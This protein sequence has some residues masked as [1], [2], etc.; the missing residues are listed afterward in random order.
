MIVTRTVLVF[1]ICRDGSQIVLC[2]LPC[3]YF[4]SNIH[5]SCSFHDTFSV[6]LF[7]THNISLI[8]FGVYNSVFIIRCIVI[9]VALSLL[10]SLEQQPI[11]VVCGLNQ[12]LPWTCKLWL[13]SNKKKRNQR[14]KQI[15]KKTNFA[16]I[17][18]ISKQFFFSLILLVLFE[19]KENLSEWLSKVSFVECRCI[20]FIGN[21]I[22]K[23]NKCSW[24]IQET[25]DMDSRL[26]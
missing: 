9:V 14:K 16:T 23:V 7:N 13:Y 20:L 12:S 2:S 3:V 21:T 17:K 19:I 25:S 22:N 6:L 5:D 4:S 11:Q 1:C 15:W 26:G 8:R 18:C 24:I 10:L